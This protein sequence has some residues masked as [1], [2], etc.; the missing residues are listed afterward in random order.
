[1]DAI[2]LCPACGQQNA[3]GA[4]YC[5]GCRSRLS[6]GKRVS[7]EEAQN[8]DEKRR[9]ANRRRRIVRLIVM[10]LLV[11]AVIVWT[12]YST[13]GFSDR[14][15]PPESDISADPAT[16]DWPMFQRGPDHSGRGSNEFSVPEGRVAW[17]FETQAPILSSPAVAQSTVYLSTGDR[18]V[19]ALD[20]ATGELIWENE[21]NGPVDSSPAVAGDSVFVGLKDGRLIALSRATG[22]LQWEFQTG[23]LI[24][25]SPSVYRGVVYIGSSDG[26]LYALDAVSGEERWSHL[27]E[28][29]VLTAP[30]VHESV[31]AVTSQD[32]RVYLLDAV[33]GNH[34]L[35]L[36]VSDTRG[37]ATIDEKMVYVADTGGLMMAIDW[38]KTELPFEKTARW[39]RTQLFWWKL[40]DTLPPLKGLVW[41]F[42][43]PRSSFVGTPAV[44]SEMVYVASASG[45]IFALDRLTG[46]LIWTYR[47]DDVVV[48]SPS[49]AGNTLF[50][51]DVAGVLHGVDTVTG[52]RK[53][54]F[55]VDGPIASTPVLAN[56]MVYVAS[57]N[58][59]LYVIK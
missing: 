34:R 24:Y 27:T 59:T 14:L 40:V 53:W 50:V 9:S 47:T 29:R 16:G 42:R 30:A 37:S 33:T 1:M 54:Q 43:R 48:G 58:G 55:Q 12:G 44:G 20:A 8:L 38:S 41:R 57:T 56:G 45:A 32:R 31:V 25:S 7:Q 4:S 35:D 23:D 26:R 51:G 3:F 39:V 10:I 2:V 46:S 21:V 17:Q 18:R 15:N 52:E 13:L 19:V 22:T 11:G 6:R 5:L 49:T 28:G 36:Q